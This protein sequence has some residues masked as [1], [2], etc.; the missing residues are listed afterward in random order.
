MN[1]FSGW[2]L[3][4]RS[5]HAFTIADN[6]GHAGNGL[7]RLSPIRHNPFFLEAHLYNEHKFLS[8]NTSQI[9]NP[10][11]LLFLLFKMAGTI[12]FDPL[13][14]ARHRKIYFE[15][16]RIALLCRRRRCPKSEQRPPLITETSPIKLLLSDGPR[17]IF[18]TCVTD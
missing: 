6:V 9:W 13:F 7:V 14:D 12:R 3:P 1:Q 17:R 11:K 2:N 5:R 4:L 10:P 15:Y 18:T 16:L 8:S